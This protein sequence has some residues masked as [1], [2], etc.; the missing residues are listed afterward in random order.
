[1]AAGTTQPPGPEARGAGEGIV[2]GV[3]LG[4]TKVLAIA[5]DMADHVV[6]RASR[7]TD[8]TNPQQTVIETVSDVVAQAGS[9][10]GPLRAIGIAAPGELD[11]AA[12]TIVAAVNLDAAGLPLGPIVAERFGV[13]AFLD[14]DGGAAALWLTARDPAHRDVAYITV[15]TGIAAGIV[16]DGALFHG[17][18]GMA[19]E[20]GHCPAVP[21]GPL[22]ACG[23]RGCLEAVASGPAVARAAAEAIGRG[24]PSVLGA[25]D[26]TGEQ[27]YA[28]ADEGDAVAL[29][30]TR[31]AAAHIGR[32]VRTLSLLYGVR[33]I[34]IGG[35]PTKAGRAFAEPLFE[36]LDQ[37]RVASPLVSRAFPGPV[38]L[39]PADADATAWGA[40]TVARRGSGQ[41]QEA[42]GRRRRREGRQS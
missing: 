19:G 7:P 16:L 42:T 31:E 13:P 17:E 39:L 38:E 29:R 11:R 4:G 34:V 15:G 9:G 21:D 24:E 33:R 5:V 23:S 22:C 6:G 41:G 26:I 25:G 12:G 20:L 3:D 1:M 8:R 2:V 28:A 35:G 40:V 30:V 32:A 37:E 18:N 27:V 14:H 36:Y 10:A